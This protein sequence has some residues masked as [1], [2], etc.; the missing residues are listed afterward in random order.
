MYLTGSAITHTPLL[1]ALL[2]EAFRQHDVVPEPPLVSEI[3]HVALAFMRPGAFNQPDPSSW[4]L[5]TTVETARSQFSPGTA[6]VVAIGGWGDS[7]GFENAAKT[8][9]G[10][11]LFAKNV[12][13]MVEATGAD[14]TFQPLDPGFG[15]LINS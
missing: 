2:K 1:Y 11:K 3:T 8:Q 12:R 5:F 15:F 4:P 14:G 7:E 6:I 13:A 9:S 10:R